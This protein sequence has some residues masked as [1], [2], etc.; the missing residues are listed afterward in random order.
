MTLAVTR[1]SISLIGRDRRHAGLRPDAT[2]IQPM[3]PCRPPRAPMPR[4]VSAILP[5]IVPRSQNQS[6]GRKKTSPINRPSWRWL[7]SQQIDELELGQGH[8]LVDELVLRDLPVLLELRRPGRFAEGGTAPAT[9]RHSVID[10]PDPVS[11]VAP[12]D[13][14]HGDDQRRQHI[15]PEPN[16]ADARS[17]WSFKGDAGLRRAHSH[18][19]HLAGA[20][21]RR[22]AMHR[23]AF[24]SRLTYELRLRQAM[25][26]VT[27]PE[28]LKT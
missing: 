28:C 27:H 23:M 22:A 7:H 9:G 11:R 13:R 4:S 21:G 16:G 15:E 26:P 2:M 6:I 3:A 17:A 25:I 10:R 20:A 12:A 5:R 1:C 24:R 8:A 14:H 19:I 18:G